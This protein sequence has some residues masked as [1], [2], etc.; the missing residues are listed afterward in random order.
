MKRIALL[1]TALILV[2]SACSKDE[3]EAASPTPLY[4]A[5]IPSI[6]EATVPPESTQEPTATPMPYENG[7]TGIRSETDLSAKRPFAI[8]INNISVAQ[9][10]CAIA[11]ADI[12]Y[13]VL[14]EG[15]IT[16][17]MAVFSDIEGIGA[18]GSMRSARSYYID[19][20]TAYN[21]IFVHAGGSDQAYSDISVKGINNID[22]VRGMYGGEIFYRDPNR[23]SGGYE[24]SLFTTSDL[25]LEY[26]P[27]F[28]Y[29]TEH[30]GGSFDYGLD[31]TEDAAPEDGYSAQSV[32]VSFDGHKT[33]YFTYDSEKGVYCM[34]Q[35]GSDYIDGNT[36]EVLGFENVLVLYAKS[37]TMDEYGRLSVVTTG[38]GQG[39][40]INGG[41]AEDINWSRVGSD[42]CFNYSNANGTPLELGVGKTY[43]CIVPTGSAITFQ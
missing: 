39:H 24:H 20:A 23:M 38:M 26:L 14:A 43:I 25:I 13:E 40:F 33:S 42:E 18:I 6:G 29:A 22:G 10:Q 34:Q 27:K 3:Q 5:D 11:S 17:M 2:F 32:D 16:R 19:L 31:F 7:L 35:Y 28:G 8:M 36:N 41:K 15:G 21:A 1:F 9:P 4:T 12:I 30:S 37:S